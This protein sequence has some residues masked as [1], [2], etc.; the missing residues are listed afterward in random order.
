[1]GLGAAGRLFWHPLDKFFRLAVSLS[2]ADRSDRSQPVT[3]ETA[4]TGLWAH[5]AA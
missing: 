5:M 3:P 2:H 1:M 4:F